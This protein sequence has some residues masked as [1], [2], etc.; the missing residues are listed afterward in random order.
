MT[1]E[2]NARMQ[3]PLNS[4]DQEIA[5]LLRDEAQRQATG[6]E[7]ELIFI[8]VRRL[9]NRFSSITARGS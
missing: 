8:R 4:V 3:R 9:A 7:R 5:E 6:L 1:T 2:A